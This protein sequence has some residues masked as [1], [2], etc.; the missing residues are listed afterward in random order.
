MNDDLA[1]LA[2]GVEAIRARLG[3]ATPGPWYAASDRLLAVHAGDAETA[4]RPVAEG[5]G[6]AADADLIA[7][8]RE[9]LERLLARVGELEGERDQARAWAWS[10]WHRYFDPAVTDRHHPPAWLETDEVPT[11]WSAASA[12]SRDE[13]HSKGVSCANN[14]GDLGRS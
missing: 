14:L 11:A 9:D 13:V 1:P 6:T 4:A 8:A 12:A 7:H 2:V 10:Q 5:V 3:R